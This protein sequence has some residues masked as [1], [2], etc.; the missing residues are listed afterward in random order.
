MNRRVLTFVALAVSMLYGVLV[1]VADNRSVIA[2][3]G[4]VVVALCW[5]AVGM[6]G[7]DPGEGRERR[8]VR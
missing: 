5:V 1:G 2:P 7:R 4:G 6:F 8:R 3:V